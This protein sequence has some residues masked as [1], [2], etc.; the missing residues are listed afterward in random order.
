M[1][2]CKVFINPWES[3]EIIKLRERRAQKRMGREMPIINEGRSHRTAFLSFSVSRK[4]MMAAVVMN[5]TWA[6]EQVGSFP[7]QKP[8]RRRQR[9]KTRR[10]SKAQM[11][12]MFLER[13]STY[14]IAWG[15]KRRYL[16]SNQVMQ[17]MWDFNFYR[18]IRF[19]FH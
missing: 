6:Q 8:E 11:Q 10:L 16:K 13:Q 2:L 7:N 18:L 4:T 14:F 1:V 9:M 17:Q 5:Y 15:S 3:G 12:R 19:Y